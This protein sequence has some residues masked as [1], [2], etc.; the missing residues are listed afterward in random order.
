MSEGILRQL[1]RTTDPSAAPS[2]YVDLYCKNGQYFFIDNSGT[3]TSIPLD[4]E[5]VQ[6]II[7]TTLAGGTGV[8]VIYNDVANTLTIG[9]NTSTFN[10]LNSALQP[11][12]NVSQ[13][14]NDANYITSSGAPVQSVNG[15]IGTL[16]N[17]AKTN[18]N[19]NF[20]VGQTIQNGSVAQIEMNA[21]SGVGDALTIFRTSSG[22]NPLWAIGSN[23][24]SGEFRVTRSNGLSTSVEL[25]MTDTSLD[26]TNKL[27]NN[28]TNPIN[29]QD[30]ATKDYV[31]TAF[32]FGKEVQ[33]FID[34]TA[35]SS[36]SGSFVTASSFTTSSKPV[37]K[38]RVALQWNFTTNSTNS[39]T[40]FNIQIDGVNCLQTDIQVEL[41]D[42]TDDITYNAFCY[43]DFSSASTHTLS[44]VMKT[45]N[46]TTATVNA[47]RAEIW[48]VS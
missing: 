2:G 35:F 1:I 28:V 26:M 31:D 47:V 27:I 21:N 42:S 22:T 44:L 7:A 36:N 46:S 8:D 45:E 25:R 33:D 11:G 3:I 23:R 40:F 29:A 48:R 17:Y 13:L 32:V 41:K 10:L 19:N 30:A 6:D 12:D 24:A 39:S 14:I 15:E 20:S 4:A 9:L 18:I 38:Y 16:I 5:S 37:G 43:I 34:S